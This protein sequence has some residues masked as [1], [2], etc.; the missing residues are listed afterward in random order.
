MFRRSAVLKLTPLWA[1]AT[2][3]C[4]ALIFAAPPPAG[5]APASE[6]GSAVVV[7]NLVTAALAKETR[8]LAVGDAVRE[9]EVIEVGSD[10]SSEIRLEDETK[11]ALGPGARLTLDKFVYDRDRTQGS[12]FVNLVKGSFRFITGLAAKPSY[13]VRVPSASITVRGTIFDVFVEESGASWLLLHEGG[14]RICNSRSQCRNHDEP[15]KLVRITGDGGVGAPNRWR[16]LPGIEKIAFGTA[17]PFVIK[18]PSID[19]DPIFTPE[20]IMDSGVFEHPRPPRRAEADPDHEDDAKPARKIGSIVDK[21]A[22]RRAEH[23][24]R[25]RQRQEAKLIK[26]ALVLT[27]VILHRLRERAHD[28]LDYPKLGHRLKT[29]LNGRMLGRLPKG[30]I[31][32]PE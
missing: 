16:S 28:K 6:I 13:V 29:H 8:T 7:V 2:A 1:K 24:E 19:P 20:E 23:L 5:A 25:H 21:L 31:G 9:S 14:V 32:K 18:T 27:P 11:L 3:L 12:I 22:K 10:G 4:L 17:F 15:G 30:P 26:G